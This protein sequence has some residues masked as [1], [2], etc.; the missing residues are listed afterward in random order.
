MPEL[1]NAHISKEVKEVS[2]LMKTRIP[3]SAED[4]KQQHTEAEHVRFD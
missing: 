2:I 4:L 1:R 3:F